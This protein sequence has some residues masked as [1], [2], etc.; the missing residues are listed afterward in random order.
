MPTRKTIR[1]HPERKY[2][3]AAWREGALC[4][5]IDE[6]GRGCLAGPVVAVALALQPNQDSDLLMDSKILSPAQRQKALAWIKNHATYG[7]NS[8]WFD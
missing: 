6:A 7:F 4:I 3:Q 5:G 8:L 2:E 1:K